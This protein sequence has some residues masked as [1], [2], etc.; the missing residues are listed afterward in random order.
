MP[1]YGVTPA[2]FVVKPLSQIQADIQSQILGTVDPQLDLSPQTPDGQFLGIYANASAG[3]WELAQIVWNS[4]NR[5]DVEGTGLDNL[6]ALIGI[7]RKG[8]DF[9][10]VVVTL[11]L[12]PGNYSASTW[13]STTGLIQT[14]V[15]LANVQGSVSQQFANVN[16]LTVTSL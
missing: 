3:V 12:L 15:L 6:G 7:P 1:A 16:Q 11:A 5:N 13:N 9:T 10:Q 8:S 4:F 14:A 2:G